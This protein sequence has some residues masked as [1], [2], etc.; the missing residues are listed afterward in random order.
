MSLIMLLKTT[1]QILSGLL[2][3]QYVQHLYCLDIT[4]LLQC[5]LLSIKLAEIL[6]T[7]LWCGCCIMRV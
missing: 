5:L 7:E 6:K 4:K 1:S 3:W 2:R